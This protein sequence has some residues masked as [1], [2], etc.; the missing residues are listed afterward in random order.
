[1][2]NIAVVFPGAESNDEGAKIDNRIIKRRRP[3]TLSFK[4]LRGAFFLPSGLQTGA[5]CQ[6]LLELLIL[7][8][9]ILDG[10]KITQYLARA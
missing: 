2:I 10:L 5:V 3:R 6:S 4:L 7:G 1:M 9:F 8:Q